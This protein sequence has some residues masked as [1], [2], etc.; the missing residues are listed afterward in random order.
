MARNS[1]IS[2]LLVSLLFISWGSPG[3]GHQDDH[4]KPGELTGHAGS[5]LAHQD[6]EDELVRGAELYHDYCSVCHGDKGNAH[7]WALH[8]LNPPPRN[9][10]SQ[11]AKERLSAARMFNAIKY[12]RPGT[13]M[14]GWGTR[15]TDEEI[16]AIIQFI[17]KSFMGLE[18]TDH[19]H[20]HIS[21]SDD[22]YKGDRR[23][24]QTLYEQNCAACHGIQGDG[25]G[26]RAYFIIPPPRN[27]TNSI[28]MR[29]IKESSHLFLAIR[30]GV[31]GTV[32]P[33]WGG[34]LSDEQIKD[35]I[36]YI[37]EAFLEQ[38]H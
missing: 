8:S 23:K 36:A 4:A 20:K 30:D 3:L 11:A 7:S 29:G 26:P 15:L 37:Q 9:F 17:R 35:I 18:Q 10:T 31:A 32:M 14:V 12:G 16:G 6:S 27:F 28:E 25:K 21:V 34:V 38:N 2:L 1:L 22:G 13:A 19:F 24:G 33:A 5:R